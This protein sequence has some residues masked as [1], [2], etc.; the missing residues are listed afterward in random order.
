M[1]KAKHWTE[2]GVPNGRIGEGIE[3]AE[4]VCSPM[5]GSNSVNRPYP[6]EVL[7]TGPPTKEYTWRD[8]WL[9]L[10]VAEDGLVGH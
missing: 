6:P 10:H 1:L 3:G 8:L 7:G 5:G 2:H 4:G 9:W